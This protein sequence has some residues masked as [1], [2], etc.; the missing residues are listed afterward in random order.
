MEDVDC[1]FV[2]FVS[3][4]DAG[5]G[6]LV[7]EEGNFVTEDFRVSGLDEKLKVRN[8]HLKTLTN[9]DSLTGGIPWKS[10]NSGLAYG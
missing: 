5:E 4:L 6:G 1:V 3:D 7:R 2:E 8:Q 9:A 10:P